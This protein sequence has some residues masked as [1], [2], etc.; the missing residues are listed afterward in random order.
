MLAETI[1]AYQQLQRLQLLT[2]WT[3]HRRQTEQQIVQIAQQRQAAALMLAAEVSRLQL[4]LLQTQL[5]QQQ[6]LAARLQAKAE[7]AA[8]WGASADFDQVEPLA[9]TVPPLPDWTL[10]QQQLQQAPQL[11]SWLSAER[12]AQA[13][14]RLAQANQRNDWRLGL[15]L[16]R[17]QANQD[18]S[19]QL[20]LSLPLGVTQP[21][22]QALSQLQ[23]EQQQLNQQLDQQQLQLRLKWHYQQLQQQAS[24]L[25]YLQQQLLPQAQLLVRQSQQAWQQG[26]LS[27]ADWLSSRQELLQTEL[28]QIEL[29]SAFESR[30]LELQLLTG[31]PLQSQALTS[32][33]APR[34]HYRALPASMQTVPVQTS[35]GNQP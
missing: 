2:D 4:R 18:T 6:L 32:I 34:Q 26:V 19:L 31:Q 16:K 1:R 20:S 27:T 22:Q 21:Q 9:A 11:Q 10:L 14:I 33:A 13:E 24:Q 3:E 15:G 35:T 7:L 17:D 30:L 28:E 25:S 5:Q 29:R 12:L 8:L 23:A